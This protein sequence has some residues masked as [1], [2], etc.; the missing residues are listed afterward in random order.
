MAASKMGTRSDTTHSPSSNTLAQ[1]DGDKVAIKLCLSAIGLLPVCDWMGLSWQLHANSACKTHAINWWISKDCKSDVV[2]IHIDSNYSYLV[3]ITRVVISC[4]P[5][6]CLREIAVSLS[7]LSGNLSN[8]LVPEPLSSRYSED[9][10]W[11]TQTMVAQTDQLTKILLL[12]LYSRAHS[13]LLTFSCC[14]WVT[15]DMSSSDEQHSQLTY[16]VCLISLN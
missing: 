13:L 4:K 6:V 14:F 10:L 8:C 7:C 11:R 3:F 5:S 16:T 9:K 12:L 2:Y 1:C 15:T